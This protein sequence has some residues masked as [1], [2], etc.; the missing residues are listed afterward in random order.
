MREVTGL[1][2]FGPSKLKYVMS[3]LPQIEIDDASSPQI[4]MNYEDPPNWNR[5]H[6]IMKHVKVM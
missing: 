6:N 2:F 3:P 1:N 5:L 4:E